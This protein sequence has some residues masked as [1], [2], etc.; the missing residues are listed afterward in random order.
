MSIPVKQYK[1][2]MRDLLFLIV[3]I[4]TLVEDDHL[5]KLISQRIDKIDKRLNKILDPEEIQKE[6]DTEWFEHHKNDEGVILPNDPDTDEY[7]QNTNI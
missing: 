2:D 5:N 4:G 7:F 1:K 6:I 3:T